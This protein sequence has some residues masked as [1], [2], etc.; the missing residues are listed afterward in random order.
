MFKEGFFE[1][2]DLGVKVPSEI[3]RNAKEKGGHTDLISRKRWVI[4]PEMISFT[5]KSMATQSPTNAELEN[6]ANWEVVN[7]DGTE[8]EYVDAKLVPIVRIF[9][10]G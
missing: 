10:R 8:K 1:I 5:K 2:E 3:D 6:G 7:D 9:S 4:V